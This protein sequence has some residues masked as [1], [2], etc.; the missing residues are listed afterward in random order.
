MNYDHKYF[1]ATVW[2]LMIFV[3]LAFWYSILKVTGVL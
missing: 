3:S 2:I 1:R